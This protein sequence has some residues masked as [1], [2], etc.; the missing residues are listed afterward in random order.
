MTR[1]ERMAIGELMVE[2]QREVE[3][4][5]AAERERCARY[6][7]RCAGDPYTTSLGGLTTADKKLL[8]A[9]SGIRSGDHL[10]TSPR[11]IRHPDFTEMRLTAEREAIV[12]F[13]TE[14]ENFFDRLGEYP[15]A[16]AVMRLREE[17]AR[18]DHRTLQEAE[19][20]E[21]DVVDS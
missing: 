11:G 7:E 13:M 21:T 12:K 14:R 4:A 19:A 2:V 16:S 18:G 6:L 15:Q 20:Q 10:A 3:Q 1:K 8:S 17:I 9:A 5:V